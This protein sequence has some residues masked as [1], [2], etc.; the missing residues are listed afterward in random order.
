MGM[1]GM[2]GPTG[3]TRG[4]PENGDTCGVCGKLAQLFVDDRAR[5]R[6]E[7]TGLCQECQDVSDEDD[8]LMGW[9]A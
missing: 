8:E 7:D 5:R 2:I 3:P 4:V 1:I 6:Y 9:P